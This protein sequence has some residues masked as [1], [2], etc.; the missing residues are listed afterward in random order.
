MSEANIERGGAIASPEQRTSAP[1][2]SGS[3]ASLDPEFLTIPAACKFSG[4]G[5]TELYL[6]LRAN[7]IRS[8]S[9][10]KPGRARG[11]RLVSVASMRK[12]LA[13]FQEGA[14]A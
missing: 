5:R 11:R 3:V 2:E 12:F 1:I 9:L 8:I 14:P 7:K 10:R 13:S 4:L 6:Q